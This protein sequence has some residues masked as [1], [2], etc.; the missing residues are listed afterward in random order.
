MNAFKYMILAVGLLSLPACSDFLDKAPD[1]MLTLEMI[2]NDKVRTEDWLAGLYTRI[3]DQWT[4]ARQEGPFSDDMA[5]STGWLKFGWNAID[6][7]TGNWSPSDVDVYGYWD[8]I[9][10][11]VRSALVFIENVKPNAAQLVT[12]QEVDLMKLEARFLIA[13]YYALL[14]ENF[15]PA[16]FNPDKILPIDTPNSE[17]AVT[18]APVDSI[19]DWVDKELLEVSKGLPAVYTDTKKFGRATSL[20]CLAVRARLLLFAAS[21]LVNGNPDYKGHVNADGVEL[22]NSTYDAS[23]WAKAAKANKELID[24]AHA[25]GKALFKEY[26]D[27]GSID[28]FQSYQYMLMRKESEGNKEILFARPS[29]DHG[30]MNNHCT[31]RGCSGNGGY[32]VTQSLVDAFFMEN[33]LPPILGYENGDV[34]KPII[35]PK[36]GYVEKGFSTAPEIR[37]TKWIE[38]QGNDEA[39]KGQVTLEGTY[40]MYCHREPRFYVSVLYNRAWY[41]TEDRTTR[42]LV[43]EWD[44]GITHDA[45]QNGYLMRKLVHPDHYSR[46]GVQPYRPSIN[47]RLGEAYLNY[48]EAL[49][50]S[51]P[52][53]PD[54]L[55]Y[56]NLIRER[57][58]VPQYGNGANMIPVPGSQEEMR[59]L[60]RRERRVELCCESGIRWLDIR[61]WKIGEE[62]LNRDFYG[63]NYLGENLTDNDNDPLA[64]FKRT[65]YQT[66][67][68]TKKNYF[69]PVPQWELDKNPNLVQNPFWK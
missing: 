24:A 30:S 49:N 13:Y 46:D 67:S 15:G 34:G 16:P 66:R 4:F 63:M 20:M 8:D 19:I 40:N 21:P 22:F 39:H 10:K 43:G 6:K 45:P 11:R 32:G 57:A 2:F 60:I 62:T 50:E 25:A 12:Q 33:G 61:R 58:G 23:K 52:G 38:C 37:N 56:L 54:I 55:K 48:A 69:N 26:N 9:P 65:V 53:N 41:R 18:Q 27:D 29:W 7:Q 5:P 31:P 17:L 68:F 64:F 51:E 14:V 59:D 1:D 36:S 42:F 44:G 28:P 35:N 47:Y 3:P